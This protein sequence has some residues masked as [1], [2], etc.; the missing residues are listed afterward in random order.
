MKKYCSLVLAL[1]S[2]GCLA[3]GAARAAEKFDGLRPTAKAAP[4][5]R[6]SPS[7]GPGMSCFVIDPA[8][9][10]ARV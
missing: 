4:A 3:V 6:L 7:G 9:R 8:Q 10:T 1:V 5:N 2:T